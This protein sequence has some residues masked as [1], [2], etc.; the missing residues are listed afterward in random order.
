MRTE[1]PTVTTDIVLWLDLAKANQIED[2]AVREHV[3]RG[4]LILR[5][6]DHGAEQ[7]PEGTPAQWPPVLNAIDR[8]VGA[9]RKLEHRLS[10]S[11]FWVTGRAG[12]PAFLYLGY[13]LSKLA[14][15]TFVHQPRNGAAVE[16]MRLDGSAA[17]ADRPPYFVRTPSPVPHTEAT[18]PVALVVSSLRQPAD[19]QIHDAMARRETRAVGIVRAHSNERLDAGAVVPAMLE[20]GELIQQACD[21][22][23]ARSGLAV[24]VAGP[25]TLAFLVGSAINPRA[26]RDVQVFEFDGAR[27]TLAYQLPYP[28][29]P[30]RNK[31]LFFSASPAGASRLALDQEL[32]SIRLER[33]PGAVADRLEIENIPAAQPKDIVHALRTREAGV[34]HFSG[35]GETGELLFEDAAGNPR[36]VPTSDLAETFRLAGSPVRLVVLSA[37]HSESHADALLA[38]VECVVVMRGPVLDADAMRFTVALYRHLAEGDSIR[39]AFDRGRLEMRLDR[40]GGAAGSAARDI[41]AVDTGPSP[42]GEPPQLLERDPGCASG[43]FLVRR[44]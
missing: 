33:S 15:I 4:A 18:A 8:L 40:P 31:V 27:Y 43:V 14:A 36:P 9:A 39:D 10:G 34:V 29:V 23:T 20:I 35:H 24:F 12:L 2:S 38:H 28:T 3:P 16:V 5:L 32:R 13:R 7:C 37:C 25:T 22:H 44:R 21:A 17:A 26:C 42:A 30:D 41:H 1:P 11:R 6:T 19:H